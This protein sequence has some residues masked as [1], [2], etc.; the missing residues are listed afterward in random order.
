VQEGESLEYAC[1]RMA[2]QACGAEIKIVKPLSPNI[3]YENPQTKEKMTIV[4]INYL[5]K[6][7]NP[8]EIKPI[9]PEQDLKWVLIED[10]KNGRGNVS[11]N[12]EELVKKEF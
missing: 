11:P 7:K 3:F 2:K 1:V 9:P 5:A 12:V 10:I 4:L 8:D 6:L